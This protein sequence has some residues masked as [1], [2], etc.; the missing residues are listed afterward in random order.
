L[1][2]PGGY[3]TTICATPIKSIVAS[4]GSIGYGS[5]SIDVP[6][7]GTRR[8]VTSASAL[9]YAHVL[10]LPLPMLLELFQVVLDKLLYQ[11]HKPRN[12]LQ[13]ILS[14]LLKLLRVLVLD[15]L[16]GTLSPL[17]GTLYLLLDLYMEHNNIYMEHLD[18]YIKHF[19]VDL[20]L[21]ELPLPYTLNP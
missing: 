3:E 16:L 12:Q 17:L 5:R 2:A 6:K 15:V 19:Y 13:N 21:Y 4:T 7:P 14:Q 8:D 9:A 18:L 20:Y 1:R 10:F 11:T